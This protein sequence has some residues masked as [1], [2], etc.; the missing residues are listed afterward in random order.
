MKTTEAE[1]FLILKHGNLYNAYKAWNKLTIAEQAD[2]PVDQFEILMEWEYMMQTN[3]PS[4][5]EPR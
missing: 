4:P 2:F 3:G 5:F 1:T